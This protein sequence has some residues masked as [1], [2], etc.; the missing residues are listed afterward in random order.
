MS[1]SRG[2]SVKK[3][4]KVMERQGPLTG[5]LP[6]AAI[7]GILLLGLIHFPLATS[8]NTSAGTDTAKGQLPWVSG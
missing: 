6:S 1:G 4:A 2:F 7:I 3:A 8:W 5:F